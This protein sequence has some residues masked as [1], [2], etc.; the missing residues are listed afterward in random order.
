MH[1]LCTYT[2]TYIYSCKH[3]Q[4]C[5]HVQCA[6]VCVCVCADVCTCGMYVYT[7][8]L[9]VVL[10]G[11]PFVGVVVVVH[12]WGVGWYSAMDSVGANVAMMIISDDNSEWT[13]FPIW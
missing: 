9:H 2:H 10:G 1:T 7:C 6:R 5:A 8:I 12:G 3:I 13:V 11:V 4:I